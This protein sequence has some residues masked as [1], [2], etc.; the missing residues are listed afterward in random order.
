M[1]KNV[2]MQK[3]AKKNAK[4]AKDLRKVKELK[5]VK[6]IKAV[7]VSA[8]VGI[9]CLFAVS[10]LHQG[11]AYFSGTSEMKVNQLSIVKGEQDQEG[12]LVIIEPEWDLA[13]E[14][15]G[16]YAMNLQPGETVVKDPQVES[17]IDYPCWVFVEVS[18]PEGWGILEKENNPYPYVTFT[19]DGTDYE[20]S[21]EIVVPEINEEDWKIYQRSDG[22]NLISYVYGCKTP[23][24]AHEVTSPVFTSIT[25][26]EFK[27]FEGGENYIF[28]RAKAIQTE[29]CPTLD[30]AAEKLGIRENIYWTTISP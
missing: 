5:I 13:R 23:L 2:K 9:L 29:G 20:Y 3:E 16:S 14:A 18:V 28:V 21:Y 22:K 4:I 11:Y 10:G 26:P 1:K 25:V 8:A 6:G 7:K 30:D 12:G 15:D 24:E 19:G 17:H 27:Q